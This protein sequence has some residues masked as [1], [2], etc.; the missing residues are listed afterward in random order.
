MVDITPKGLKML[1]DQP[2]K[3]DDEYQ[4]IIATGQDTSLKSSIKI[5]TRCIRCEKDMYPGFYNVGMMIQKGSKD[6][7]NM[8]E[9][10]VA[11]IAF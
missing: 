7:K 5:N 3:L 9:K 6:Q 4:L 10:L 1:T 8:I 2:M 11:E